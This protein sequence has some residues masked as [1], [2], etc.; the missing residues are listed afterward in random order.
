MSNAFASKRCRRKPWPSNESPYEPVDP[1]GNPIEILL[2]P[3]AK[4][5]RERSPS[6][7]EVKRHQALLNSHNASFYLLR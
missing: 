2:D 6:P 5:S 7:D 1:S 4:R 3:S